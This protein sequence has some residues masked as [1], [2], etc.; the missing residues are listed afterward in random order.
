M[1]GIH[2]GFHFGL[3]NKDRVNASTMTVFTYF[4]PTVYEKGNFRGKFDFAQVTDKTGATDFTQFGFNV[5][6]FFKFAKNA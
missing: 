4:T 3:P 6:V 2:A 5:M 1:N